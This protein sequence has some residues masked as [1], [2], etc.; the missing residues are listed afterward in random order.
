MY[1]ILIRE[2]FK[3][4]NITKTKTSS[5]YEFVIN[6][7]DISLVILYAS[8]LDLYWTI[9]SKKYIPVPNDLKTCNVFEIQGSEFNWCETQEDEINLIKR[10]KKINSSF[11]KH[12]E[13]KRLFSNGIITWHSDDFPYDKASILTMKKIN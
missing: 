12:D 6:N 4:L 5:G 11:K 8:N 1:N 7:G 10:N 3:V 2:G 13:Y 9:E